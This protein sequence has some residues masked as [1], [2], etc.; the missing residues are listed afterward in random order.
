MYDLLT[1][2]H[3]NTGLALPPVNP[4]KVLKRIGYAVENGKV[5]LAERPSGLVGALGVVVDEPWWSTQKHLAD[6]FFY[7]KPDERTGGVAVKL[8]KAARAYAASQ[9]MPL[10]VNLLT[11]KDLFRKERFLARMG[12]ERVGSLHV[13]SLRVGR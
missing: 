6:T 12:F 11:G 10:F 4:G 2:M 9:Q 13:Q 3:K 5:F 8:L 7:V 1:D